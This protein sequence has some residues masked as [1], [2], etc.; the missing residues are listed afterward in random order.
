MFG[1]R[2]LK[3]LSVSTLLAGTIMLGGAGATLA[4]DEAA[5]PAVAHP[6]HIHEGTCEDLNPNPIQ[7]LTEVTPWINEETDDE[8]VNDPQGTLAAPMVLRSETD[9]E[10]SLEDILTAPHAINIHESA[11]NIDNYIACGDIGGVVVDDD[12]DNLAVALT[13]VNDSGYHG[14]AFL[15]GDGDTTNVKV[16]LAEPA[17]SEEP[18]ATPVS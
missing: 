7:P 3:S 9:V 8:T 11:E 10:M 1:S 6:A 18:A 12:G 4:Q 17:M 13:P 16:W 15:T 2:S 5:A 14:I